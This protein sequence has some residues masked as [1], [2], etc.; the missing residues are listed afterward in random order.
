MQRALL[1]GESVLSAD[2]RTLNMPICVRGKTIATMRLVKPSTSEPWTSDE[3][4]DIKTLSVQLSNTLDS[5]RLYQEA[6]HRAA[7]EQAISEISAQI[8]AASEVETILQT[9]AEEL[10]RRLSRTSG[11]SITMNK[12]LE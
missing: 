12:I 6:Q 7:R 10:G 11:V 2:K 4:E 5:A 1:E 8:S 9:A 3:I